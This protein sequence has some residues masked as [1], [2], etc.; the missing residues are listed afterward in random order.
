MEKIIEKFIHMNPDIRVVGLEGSQTTGKQ[1]EHSD[2]DVTFLTTTVE[3]YLKDD[4]WLDFF[5]ERIIMQKPG[6]FQF[7]NGQKSYPFLM[8]FK[9]GQRIDL[10]IASIEAFEAYRNWESTVKIIMDL[11][12]RLTEEQQP[13]E[14]SFFVRKPSETRFE[15]V[16]NE[17]FWV[18]PYIV[19]GCSRKQFMYA[20][21][22]IELIRQQLIEVIGWSIGEAHAYE[23]NL[24]SHQKNLQQYMVKEDWE[25]LQLT[26]DCSNYIQMRQALILLIDLMER[27]AKPLALSYNYP[28]STEY[29][30]VVQFVKERL[31]R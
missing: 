15:K 2:I 24:G 31:W 11:D 3:K 17:F 20:V 5:G 16:V 8:L 22:H 19:K 9:N 30:A 27:Y 29:D 23:V 28:Y 26:Y 14:S 10:K 7:E 1:D 25:K 18:V 21:Q 4:M 6:E 12:G 13:N